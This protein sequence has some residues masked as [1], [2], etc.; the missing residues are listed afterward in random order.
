MGTISFVVA[1]VVGAIGFAVGFVLGRSQ[2]RPAA[3]ASSADQLKRLTARNAE[4]EA[5]VQTL[6]PAL[7][8]PADSSGGQPLLGFEGAPPPEED[9]FATNT[10]PYPAPPLQLSSTPRVELDDLQG[11]DLPFDSALPA[12]PPSEPEP[13]TVVA[14]APPV[15]EPPPA[16]APPRTA[17]DAFGA[18]AEAPSRFSGTPDIFGGGSTE[19]PPRPKRTTAITGFGLEAARPVEAPFRSAPLTDVPSRNADEDTGLR[20]PVD[21]EAARRLIQGLYSDAAL[22][23][24]NREALLIVLARFLRV[25]EARARELGADAP[26]AQPLS[27]MP[28]LENDPALNKGQRETALLLYRRLTRRPG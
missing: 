6:P 26:P 3:A 5:L 14:A 21:F 11:V 13:L 25:G 4:L 1:G 27:F 23:T 2:A 15:P 22:T 9:E 7:D 17:F 28:M 18:T 20:R 24:E 10:Q 16:P 19:L 12:P 8:Q